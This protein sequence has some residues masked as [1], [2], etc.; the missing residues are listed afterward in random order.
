[1]GIKTIAK[2]L[3]VARNTVR[4]AQRSDAPPHYER[5]PRGSVVDA[6]ES[7]IRRLLKDFPEMPASVKASGS[8]GSGE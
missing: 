7:E 2:R 3:G 8:A 4:A 5:T 6:A 1:M